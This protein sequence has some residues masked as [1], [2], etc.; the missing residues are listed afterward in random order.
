M[1]DSSLIARRADGH[2]GD[3]SG[4]IAARTRTEA[5]KTVMA[6]LLRPAVEA[7]PVGE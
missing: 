1:P 4:N 7:V 6:D 3:G 2:E 5:G